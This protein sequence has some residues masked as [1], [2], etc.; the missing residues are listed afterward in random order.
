MESGVVNNVWTKSVKTRN[1]MAPVNLC[2]LEGKG[3][4][5]FNLGFGKCPVEEGDE[6]QF[7]YEMK[8]GE[9]QIDKQT[10]K[11]TSKN[12]DY[13]AG[14]KPPESKPSDSS[15]GGSAPKNTGG[16]KSYSR[17]TFPL[18][19]SDGQ[20]SILRQHAFTQA[21]EIYRCCSPRGD[22]D[23]EELEGAVDQVIQLAYKI[24]RYTS[25]DDLRE[26]MKN[27]NE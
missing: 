16:G 1:G 23:M 17:G 2:S 13:T 20:R 7:N 15:G 26:E 21:S 3:D 5:P 11:I 9:G 8:Y 6:I 25:G 24:E 12:N 4:F 18:E 22:L 27:E 14:T 10:L 19:F